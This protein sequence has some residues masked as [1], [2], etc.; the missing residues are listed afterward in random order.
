MCSVY[1]PLTACRWD[2]FQFLQALLWTV[3]DTA[4]GCYLTWKV[5]A[6]QHQRST[7]AKHKNIQKNILQDIPVSS[8]LL[9]WREKLILFIS[10]LL[11]ND[12]KNKNL[13]PVY[14]GF[15]RKYFLCLPVKHIVFPWWLLSFILINSN[16]DYFKKFSLMLL[17]ANLFLSLHTSHCTHLLILSS[18][19]QFHTSVCPVLSQNPTN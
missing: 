18:V 7:S 12:Q 19:Q 3:A 13:N 8:S 1:Y 16:L 17:V 6:I 2:R 11:E 15:E 9:D 4:A 14:T 10:C 5:M